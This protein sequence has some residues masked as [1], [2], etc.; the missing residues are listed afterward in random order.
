MVDWLNNVLRPLS[1]E[2]GTEVPMLGQDL[3]LVQSYRK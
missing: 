1:K 2:V 3:D